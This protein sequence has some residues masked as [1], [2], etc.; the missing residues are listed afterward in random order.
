MCVY[1][2]DRTYSLSKFQVYNMLLLTIVTSLYIRA[3]ELTL[4]FQ[5]RSNKDFLCEMLIK[6]VIVLE[7][8]RMYEI[9]SSVGKRRLRFYQFLV[10]IISSFSEAVGPDLTESLLLGSNDFVL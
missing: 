5:L 1:R 8:T 7:F 2:E 6:I 4:Y 10:G 9:L 3:P